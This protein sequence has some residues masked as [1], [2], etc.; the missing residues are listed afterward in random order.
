M[1]I[2]TPAHKRPT[3]QYLSRMIGCQ[4][5]SLGAADCICWHDQGTGPYPVATPLDHD[6]GLKWRDKPLPPTPV[7]HPRNTETVTVGVDLAK[8]GPDETVIV[9]IPQDVSAGG[10]RTLGDYLRSQGIPE[11][12]SSQPAP[13]PGFAWDDALSV[14]ANMARA[15]ALFRSTLE[16]TAQI[17]EQPIT[18]QHIL[19]AAMKHIND[20]AKTYDKPQGERSMGQT[21]AAFNAITGLELDESHG[22]LLMVLLKL[23]RDA[24]APGGHAD[25]QEDAVSYAA[26]LAEAKRKGL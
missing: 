26:L 19:R 25:S 5:K 22:W 10:E 21:V 11:P 16:K 3:K 23:V 14:T 7:E 20:R 15:G 24:S 18:A 17:E 1:S 2:H 6:T 4:S 13:T 9:K 8:P 12:D